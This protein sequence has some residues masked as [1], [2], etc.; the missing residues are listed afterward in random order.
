MTIVAATFLFC[1]LA[2]ISLVVIAKR[3][4]ELTIDVKARLTGRQS[5]A[6]TPAGATSDTPTPAPRLVAGTL[7]KSNAGGP[8]A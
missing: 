1:V 3:T 5:D 4:L 6:K 7:R 8:N 2:L